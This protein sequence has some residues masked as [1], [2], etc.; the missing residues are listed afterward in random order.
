SNTVEHNVSAA[1]LDSGSIGDA[2]GIYCSQSDDVVV[3]NNVI[4]HNTGSPNRNGVGGGVLASYCDRLAIISNTIQHNVAAALAGSGDG[5]GGGL[6]L[7]RSMDLN[8]DRNL[9]VSNTAHYGGGLSV[10]RYS[11]FT[12]TNN[13]VADNYADNQG[14]GMAFEASATQYVTG[15]LAHNTFVANTAGPAGAG[16]NAIHVYN[17]GVALALTNNIICSHTYGIVV[18]DSGSSATL[19]NSLFFNNTSGDTS[20]A[21]TIVNNNAITGQNPLLDTNY[22]L[23]DGSPAI[24]AGLT[25]GWPLLDVDGETR[26]LILP[27]IGADDHQDDI[28]CQVYLPLVLRS[29]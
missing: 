22:H 7:A 24:L 15:T 12:M 10:S 18:V 14:G 23:M 27:D 8:I 4:R 25:I 16:R 5:Y 26:R 6:Y 19:D 28:P 11:S 9:I 2:G 17:A 29:Y 21:G 3:S 20:G 13:I 1:G